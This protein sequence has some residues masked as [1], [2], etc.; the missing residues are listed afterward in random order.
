MCRENPPAGEPLCKPPEAQRFPGPGWGGGMDDSACC[1][2]VR[3]SGVTREGTAEGSAARWRAASLWG[4]EGV[5]VAGIG[6]SH[7]P[8]TRERREDGRREEEEL[9]G[10]SGR[11]PVGTRRGLPRRFVC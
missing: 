4:F 10:V 9:D 3:D 7:P 8:G 6:G 5:F 2:R 1:A 11:S